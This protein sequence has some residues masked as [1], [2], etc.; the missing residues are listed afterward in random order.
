MRYSDAV[1]WHTVLVPE[2]TTHLRYIFLTKLTH[3][4]HYNFVTK[5]WQKNYKMYRLFKKSPSHFH[6]KLWLFGTNIVITYSSQNYDNMCSHIFITKS[7]KHDIF[8]FITNLSLLC[9][10]WHFHHKIMTFWYS[11]YKNIFLTKLSPPLHFLYRLRGNKQ[12]H[13]FVMNMWQHKLSWI[14]DE[15]VIT[16]FI[17]KSQFYNENMQ[18][19]F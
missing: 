6:W 19:I 17:S 7:W 11:C 15:N 1:V 4:R 2:K 12:Q 5:L 13:D 3:F 8:K 18:D 16:T 10:P 14:C 9:S